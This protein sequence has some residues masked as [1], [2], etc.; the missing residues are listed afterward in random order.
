VN[1]AYLI[2]RADPIGGAQI[3][4]RDLAFAVRD[5]GHRP[6]LITSGGGPLVDGFRQAGIPVV[7]LPNLTA[8]IRPWRDVQALGEIRRALLELQPDLVAAHSSKAGLL[9]RVAGRSLRIP[10]VFTVHGWAFTPGVPGARAAVYRRLE[11]MAGPLAS[12]LITVSEFDRRLA[13]DARIAAP[14]RIVTVHNGMPDV[15]PSLRADPART[16][17]RI[18]M[19]ARFEPQ[20][21]HATLI[22]ALAGLTQ[23]PW[24]LDLVGEGPG[25]PAMERLA[26]ELGV[27]ERIRFLGQRMDVPR[28]LADAQVAVLITNWE[29]LPLSILEAMRAGLP[30]VA[31]DVGGIGETIHDGQTGHLVA[32][33][34][35]EQVRERLGRLLADAALRTAFGAAGRA[36][37]ERQFT[38]EHCVSRTLAVYESVIEAGRP[39]VAVA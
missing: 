22:H 2:T 26:G 35:V 23:L 24:E 32:R 13:L 33:G 21:D 12:R 31:S 11:R 29:G 28:L 18:V 27:G 19:V 10:V 7:L 1:I 16:P 37:Y 17:P 9:G 39:R 6:A 14:D 36:F 25:M 30:V 5:H 8:P 3:H 34:A 20:K 4:V 38:L 15:P